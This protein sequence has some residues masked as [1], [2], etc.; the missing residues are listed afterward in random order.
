MNYYDPTDSLYKQLWIDKNNGISKYRSVTSRPSYLL[1]ETY[2]SP[3]LIRMA[4]QL[5]PEKDE[6]TQTLEQSTD[7]GK[8]WANVFTG[9]YKRQAGTRAP[10][11]DLLTAEELIKRSQAWHDPEHKW[12]TWRDTLRIVEPRT[13]NLKRAT[14]VVLDNTK[15]SF[16]FERAYGEDLITYRVHPNG[17]EFTVNGN[18]NPIAAQREKHR[19][20]C[21]RGAGYQGF[22]TFLYGLPMSLNSSTWT[23]SGLPQKLKLRGTTYWALYLTVEGA[24]FSD[25]WCLYFDLDT[26]ALSAY[27]FLPA[28]DSNLEGDYL[29]LHGT[30]EKGG[31]K[32]PRLRNWYARSN[33]AFLGSDVGF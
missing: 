17:C 9:V 3:Q 22:Y 31:V 20:S 6:V 19:L 5:D 13:R 21:E 25:Q 24:P 1:M 4:Y 18:A 30:L 11:K 27:E 2:D 10:D 14:V 28:E 23:A 16:Y 33:D 12:S 29:I 15:Q 32:F 26:Y 7:A 8:N